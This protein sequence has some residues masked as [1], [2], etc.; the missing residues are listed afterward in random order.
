MHKT[1]G[2]KKYVLPPQIK[3]SEVEKRKLIGE[4]YDVSY[5]FAKKIFE[6]FPGLIKSVVLFGSVMKATVTKGSDI[7]ILVIMDDTAITPSRKFVDWYN[8]ELANLIRKSDPRL[9]VNTVT[10][11]TFWE[12]IKVGEPVAI[13][14]LRYGLPLI[15]TGYYEPLQY[16]L[17]NGRIK[18]TE[19]AIY[20]ALT[21]S[22]WHL[23][24][25]NSR[26]LS[27]IID[28]YWVMIDSAHAALMKY[29]VVPP[30]PEHVEKLLISTFV[31]NKKLDK[32]YVSYYHELW[33]AS[34]AVIHG[35]LLKTS[36]SDFDRY[37]LMAE[38]FHGKMKELVEK[39]K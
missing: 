14:V 28:L 18:P 13:N 36:G 6:L 31:D 27:S 20:N 24:R 19:E 10:L 39:K 21:R 32:K 25:A 29:G 37:R 2:E 35:E 33:S 11:T 7:D 9:H 34:K 22:P 23:T 3:M 17:R 5:I 38:E 1:S 26:I 12:N 8:I 15:D 16:L 30:S 4:S